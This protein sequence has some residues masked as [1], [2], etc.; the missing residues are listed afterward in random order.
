M[1]PWLLI[2]A[3]FAFFILVI[4]FEGGQVQRCDSFA[5][6]EAPPLRLPIAMALIHAPSP[7]EI[8]S[9]TCTLSWQRPEAIRPSFHV[10]VFD[11]TFEALSIREVQIT[12]NETNQFRVAG[13]KDGQVMAF[14]PYL[15]KD[16]FRSQYPGREPRDAFYMPF[17]LPQN[18][19]LGPPSV[20]TKARFRIDFDILSKGMVVCSTNYQADFILQRKET[21]MSWASQIFF[22]L[23]MPRF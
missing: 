2:G 18:P 15:D 21:K 11:A 5:P 20:G 10:F 7:D 13:P 4:L 6:Y 22:K 23:L 8:V 19:A 14:R 12:I 9:R 17:L 1:R 16:A 3:T